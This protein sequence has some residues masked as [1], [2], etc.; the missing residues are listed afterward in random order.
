MCAVLGKGF[1]DHTKFV[2][3]KLLLSEM[4]SYYFIYELISFIKFSLHTFLYN[5]IRIPNKIRQIGLF[6]EWD[7]CTQGSHGEACSGGVI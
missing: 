4:L 1:K 7:T 5:H 3:I 2:Q 6:C